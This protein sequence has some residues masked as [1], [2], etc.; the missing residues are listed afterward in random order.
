MSLTEVK[1]NHVNIKVQNLNHPVLYFPG[2][3]QQLACNHSRENSYITGLYFSNTFAFYLTPSV[4]LRLFL[5]QNS[6]K[7]RV[8]EKGGRKDSAYLE[9]LLL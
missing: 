5:C 7:E 3:Q 2:R 1:R 8:S 9:H 4:F 6:P